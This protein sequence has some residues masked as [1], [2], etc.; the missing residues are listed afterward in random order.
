LVLAHLQ[1][2]DGAGPA[3]LQLHL[4]LGSWGQACEVAVACADKERVA[5]NY[6]VGYGA[7]VCFASPVHIYGGERMRHTLWGVVWV[8][9]C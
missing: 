7:F 1:A 2:A 5:G 4:A 6:K 9:F 8:V 3:L